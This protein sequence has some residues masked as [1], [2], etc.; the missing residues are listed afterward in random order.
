M[1]DGATS[2]GRKAEVPDSGTNIAN[3]RVISCE[4]SGALSVR[5]ELGALHS[6]HVGRVH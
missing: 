4:S 5:R 1:K 6:A 2:H 3:M